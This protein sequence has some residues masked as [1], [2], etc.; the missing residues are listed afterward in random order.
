[1]IFSYGNLLSLISCFFDAKLITPKVF[2]RMAAAADL[3]G[4]F[5]GESQFRDFATGTADEHRDSDRT[6]QI[7]ELQLPQRKEP[8][9]DST[10]SEW[11]LKLAGLSELG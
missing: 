1:L 3:L 9:R 5:H 7:R 6:W 4:E 10:A 11:P 2:W 8:S